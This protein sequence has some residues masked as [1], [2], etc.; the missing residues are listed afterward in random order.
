MAENESPLLFKA[1]REALR[2]ALTP[3][4]QA[5]KTGAGSFMKRALPLCIA[6]ISI[7]PTLLLA[8]NWPQWRGPQRDGISH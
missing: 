7:V 2:I 6:A 3:V 1:S 5:N 8:E 4:R